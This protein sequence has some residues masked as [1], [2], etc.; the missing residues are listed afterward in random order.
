MKSHYSPSQ[1]AQALGVSES[2]VKRW[3]NQG[4][5]DTE[6]TAGG[7]RRIP[8]SSVIRF[9]RNHEHPLGEPELLSL[10]PTASGSPIGIEAALDEAVEALAAGDEERFR[11]VG[12]RLYLDGHSVAE[13]CDQVLAPAF[14]RLGTQ[15]QHGHLEIYQERR[16]CEI[17]L[18]LLH[19]LRLA[20]PEVGRDAPVALGGTLAGDWYHLPT[21][22][23]ELTLREAGWQAQSLGSSHP[24]ETLA[25]AVRDRRPRLFWISASHAEDRE[26]LLDRVGRIYDVAR[27]V[28]TALVVG[29][30]ILDEDLRRRARCSVVCEDLR[31]LASFASALEPTPDGGQP[32]H[33]RS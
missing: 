25:A 7:H 22:M 15:W 5:I 19:E 24:A 18:K 26:E 1:V 23:C 13:I 12:F 14:Q 8:V 32:K 30:R 20:L 2:S 11:A 9:T 21:T 29:G 4:L 10:P 16:G 33:E 28:G 27:D 17:C 3:C 31:R 6:R